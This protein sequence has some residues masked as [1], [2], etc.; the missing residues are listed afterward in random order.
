MVVCKDHL[1][2]HST[3]SAAANT[4]SVHHLGL[5]S[6]VDRPELRA[7]IAAAAELAGAAGLDGW[8]SQEAGWPW[9]DLAAQ[10]VTCLNL[11]AVASLKDLEVGCD[12]S[13]VDD[14]NH[15]N[16]HDSWR[17]PGARHDLEFAGMLVRP[18]P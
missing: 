5:G 15:C 8:K 1:P 13:V 14:H 9:K 2:S 16:H 7:D 17:D 6:P 3:A 10:N 11:E 12:Y 18:R 4:D